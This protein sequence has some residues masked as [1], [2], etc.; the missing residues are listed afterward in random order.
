MPASSAKSAAAAAA[1]TA[2]SAAAAATAAKPARLTTTATPKST[3][4][5]TAT[6]IDL[7]TI[8]AAAFDLRTAPIAAP[9]DPPI[10]AVATATDLPVVTIAAGADAPIVAVSAATDL[11]VVAGGGRVAGFAAM[12]TG[13]P[14]ADSL[15]VAA[16]RPVVGNPY[17]RCRTCAQLPIVAADWPVST[18]PPYVDPTRPLIMAAGRLVTDLSIVAAGRPMADLR[19]VAARRLMADP[20]IMGVLRLVARDC[21]MMPTA[22]RVVDRNARDMDRGAAGVVTAER[23]MPAR[24]RIMASHRRLPTHARVMAFRRTMS[25]DCT[26]VT[27][28]RRM[29]AGPRVVAALGRVR[30]ADVSMMGHASSMRARPV[31]TELPIVRSMAEVAVLRVMRSSP[32]MRID[33]PVDGLDLRKEERHRLNGRTGRTGSPARLIDGNVADLGCVVTQ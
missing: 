23:P 4:T 15:T 8:T 27:R 2:K 22:G 19:V 3:S 21:R 24:P 20:R 31:V 7:R 16:A 17:P 14:V 13:R 25:A 12:A 5:T 9:T 26:I 18:D 10:M 28:R 33:R 29:I 1:A 32:R 11:R 6:T 30:T